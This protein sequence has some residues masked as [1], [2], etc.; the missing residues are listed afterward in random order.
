MNQCR[1]MNHTSRFDKFIVV[2]SCGMADEFVVT[3]PPERLP[4]RR[5]QPEVI[6]AYWDPLSPFCGQ[7]KTWY[8]LVMTNIAMENHNF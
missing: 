7:K 2:K 6:N 3:L 4:L 1:S 8:P 5:Y